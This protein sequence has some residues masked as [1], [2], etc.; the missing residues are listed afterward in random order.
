MRPLAD[1]L[2]YY[3][4]LG[5]APGLEALE[6]MRDFY[7]E[8]RFNILKDPEVSQV[9]ACISCSVEWWRGAWSFTAQAK[10]R[11]ICWNER[12]CGRGGEHGVYVVPWS[13]CHQ[14]TG[15][16][17]RNRWLCK[18]LCYDPYAL[19]LS[20]MLKEMLCWEWR[21]VHYTKRNKASVVGQMVE[22]LKDRKW[23]LRSPETCGLSAMRCVHSSSTKR[24]LA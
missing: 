13:L 3:S 1:R 23:T 16:P 10:K 21:L 20:I 15:P 11:M 4:N 8:T 17:D 18:N 2:R 14:D 7:P 22:R 6:K 9:W 5:V 19:Y 12:G 24:F